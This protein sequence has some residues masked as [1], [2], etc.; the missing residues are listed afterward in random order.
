[1]HSVWKKTVAYLSILVFLTSGLMT[2]LPVPPVSAAGLPQIYVPNPWVMVYSPSMPV[3]NPFASSN[4][5]ANTFD[6]PLY[7]YAPTTNGFMPILATGDEVLPS[8][9]S[10]IVWLRKGLEW[11]NGSA[12]LP[13]TAWDVYTEYY[14]GTKIF[15]WFYPFVNASTI[16]VLNNYT[17][18]FVIKPWSPSMVYFLLTQRIATP[19]SAWKPMLQLAESVNAKNATAV[20]AASSN[21]REF[22]APPWFLGPYYSVVSVPY[23]IDQ[24]EP[25]NVLAEWDSVFPYHTW[26]YYNPEIIVWFSGGNGQTLNGALAGLV[27]WSQ[28]GYSPAQFKILQGIGYDNLFYPQFGYHWAYITNPTRYPWNMSWSPLVREAMAYVQNYTESVDAW[29]AYG[30]TPWL[31]SHRET[32][33]PCQ[34]PQ[35]LENITPKV[36]YDPAKA[37]AL[38]EQAGFTLK[39]GQWYMP[40]G[41]PFKLTLLVPGGWTDVDTMGS[42]YAAQLTTF[43]IPTTVDAIDVSTLYGDVVPSGDYSFVEASLPTAP[44]Y[45]T[46]WTMGWW[47]WGL[48]YGWNATANYPITL[49]NGTKTVFNMSAW[50]DKEAAETPL[51]AAYNESWLEVQA[52]INTYW[53]FIQLGTRPNPAEVSTR[54]F[55]I[56]WLLKTPIDTQGV[57]FQPGVWGLGEATGDTGYMWSLFGVTPNGV[58]SPL[59]QAM[60]TKTLSP[61]WAE[62]FGL[63][64]NYTTNYAVAALEGAKVSLSATPTSMTQGSSTTMTASVTYSNGT[65]ASGVAVNFLSN[66]ML[67]GSAVTGTNGEATYTYT[68]VAAGTYSLMADLASAPSVTSNAVSLTVTSKVTPTPTPT[69]VYPTLTLSANATSIT[70]GSTVLL[71]VKAAFTN[72]TAAS[73]YSVNFFASGVGIGSSTTGTNGQATLAYTPVAAGTYSLMADLASAPSVTSN[74]VSLTVTSR[75]TPPP[76]PTPTPTSSSAMLY[77]VVV[78]VVVV[79][80][81]VA[82]LLALTR[83][84]KKGPQPTANKRN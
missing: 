24:L 78:V 10:V 63:P 17:I 43:G 5:L 70:Q 22:V 48:Q 75:V 84:G 18:E 65:S 61:E 66:G 62:L 50:Y 83:R 51:S 82:A 3:W 29:D 28:V 35:W 31:P 16:R 54:V 49:P 20:S 74:A 12:T 2:G 69:A 30:I 41:Q 79:I 9:G 56:T 47:W 27:D 13:F 33:A 26:Q 53:P 8:N 46:F 39:N 34:F 73:G 45:A 19:Y 81:V 42:S 77:A 60:A 23:V 55:N 59:A 67:V 14:I 6:L 15:G 52:F 11:Y 80:V 25:S 57:L 68:P 64:L 21:I 71:T 38:L 4:L 40:N 7:I 72:G 1:M 44:S 58:P 76:P 32:L 36:Y 37:K